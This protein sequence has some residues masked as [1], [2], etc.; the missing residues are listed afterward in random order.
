M[1][2]GMQCVWTL[3]LS[4]AISDAHPVPATYIIRVCTN[5]CV[6]AFDNRLVYNRTQCKLT[7]LAVLPPTI[8]TTTAAV[9]ADGFN[10]QGSKQALSYTVLSQTC[11]ISPTVFH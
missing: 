5:V 1:Y 10:W 6:F 11:E 2:D 4:G 7:V 9:G 8:I 3:A